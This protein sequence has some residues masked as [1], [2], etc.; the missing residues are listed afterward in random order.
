VSWPRFL[1]S[2]SVSDSYHSDCFDSAKARNS[3]PPNAHFGTAA[4]QIV[5]LI[6]AC[7]IAPVGHFNEEHEVPKR[8]EIQHQ[9]QDVSERRS[10]LT[11]DHDSHQRMRSG[12]YS[13]PNS[14]HHTIHAET[15]S[16]GWNRRSIS[17]LI[18]VE[19]TG[20]YVY[21]TGGHIQELIRDFI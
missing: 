6:E 21:D 14:E 5:D 11:R 20:D 3:T 4:A 7:Y 18:N 16:G 12:T 1:S 8:V 15:R 10:V 2:E 9:T 19:K 17:N 13:R